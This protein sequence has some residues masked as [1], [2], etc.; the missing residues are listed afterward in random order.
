MGSLRESGKA[1]SGEVLVEAWEEKALDTVGVT[2]A[3]LDVVLFAKAGV[4]IE[5]LAFPEDGANRV[6]GRFV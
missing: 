2:D 5:G 6:V 3:D 4:G 1:Y